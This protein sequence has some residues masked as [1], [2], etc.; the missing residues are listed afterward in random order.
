M[1]PYL[2]PILGKELKRRKKRNKKK[3]SSPETDLCSDIRTN[4]ELEAT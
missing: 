1:T 4:E 3:S 2:T